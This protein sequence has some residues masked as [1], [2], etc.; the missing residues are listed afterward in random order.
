MR[1]FS[2]Y[3]C[4][5]CHGKL[6][7]ALRVLAC[8]SCKN[9]Y[10]IKESSVPI[11]LTKQNKEKHSSFFGF[12][13]S[14]FN[15]PFLYNI[16][17]TFKSNIYR[18]ASLGLLELAKNK[19][20]L[21]VGCGS[22]VESSY[23]EYNIQDLSK[24][25]AFDISEAFVLN[26]KRNCTKKGSHFCIA[27]AKNMPYHDKVFDIVLIPFVLHHMEE[28]FVDILKEASRVSKKYVVVFDH[29]KEKKRTFLSVFQ[30]YYWKIFDG[31]YQYLDEDQWALVLRE[32]NIIKKIRTGAIGSHVFKF[33]IKID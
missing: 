10:R 18:D 22:N 2:V 16:F 15:S 14:L 27:S 5:N 3:S 26:A 31:G 17:V 12:A 8:S 32:F 21:N 4:P 23:L 29:I 13:R 25:Y 1:D 24:F 33:I 6:N 11:F 30:D 28:Q 7:S 20:L 9:K 19:K